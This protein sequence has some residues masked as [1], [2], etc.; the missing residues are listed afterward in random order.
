MCKSGQV[1]IERRN[2]CLALCH[3]FLC[4]VT[5]NYKSKSWRCGD[6]LLGTAAH[7]VNLP[8]GDAHRLTEG[9]RY[10]IDNC[11]DAVF[12]EKRTDRGNIIQHSAWSVAVDNRCIFVIVMFFEES[13]EFLHIESFTVISGIEFRTSSVHGNKISK[14]PAVYTVIQYEDT[15]AR[16]RHGSTGGFQSED[17][18][19]AED[20]SFIVGV[21]KAADLFTGFFVK[22]YK[23]LIEIRV[24]TFSAAGEAHVFGNLRRTRCHNFIHKIK[25]FFFLLFFLNLFF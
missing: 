22:F 6:D 5:D 16:F 14:S 9:G 11:H 13:F 12:L 10:R 18:L 15:V 19:S 24:C 23:V 7:N 3:G 1:C 17:S 25:S 2:R 20:K 21:E 8:V 4:I